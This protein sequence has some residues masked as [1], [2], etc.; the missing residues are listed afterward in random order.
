MFESNSIYINIL[1]LIASPIVGMHPLQR[2]A[3]HDHTSHHE[4]V[5]SSYSDQEN[6]NSS[7]QEDEQKKAKE[8]AERKKLEELR[9][10]IEELAQQEDGEKEKI[11][12]EIH[13]NLA[14]LHNKA[15]KRAIAIFQIPDQSKVYDLT[16]QEKERV[17]ELFKVYSVENH[18]QYK[19]VKFRYKD[20][21]LLPQN[22][23]QAIYLLYSPY[24]KNKLTQFPSILSPLNELQEKALEKQKEKKVATK[25]DANKVTINEIKKRVEN[26]LKQQEG[27]F[28]TTKVKTQ[29]GY[30]AIEE[31]R[32]GDLVACYDFKNKKEIYNS[33]TYADK[34]HLLNHIQIIINDEVLQ[35]AAEHKFYIS[36]TNSWARAKDLI[37]SPGL[38]ALLDPRIQDVKEVAEELD[39]IR[40]SVNNQQNYYITN[41][42][43][44]VHNF[45]LLDVSILWG[46]GEGA[47]LTW[48]VL[49]PT[50]TAAATGLIYWIAGKFCHVDTIPHANIAAQQLRGMHHDVSNPNNDIF[51][52]AENNI[53]NPQNTSKNNPDDPGQSN[54]DPKKDDNK[55]K[56]ITPEDLIKDLPKGET[57]KGKAK[58][59]QKPDK[60]YG[61]AI[62]DFEKL[63]PRDIKEIPN[64]KRGILPDGRDVNVRHY[65]QDGRATL[66]I[67]NPNKS[68]I[69]IRYGT[70]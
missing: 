54:I 55:D 28:G 29:T 40:I 39:V 60:T 18:G 46:I 52:K 67:Q 7:Q 58:I 17:K 62:K 30:C 21:E 15:E 69:K 64:G 53:P 50:L 13:D 23:E 56:K 8:E 1:I 41:N 36:S 49:G 19:V 3:F 12:A 44:L 35:V 4:D 22:R 9:S 33:V 61:D 37:D 11:E 31:L 63:N 26:R 16:D 14:L 10:Y 45:L 6:D 24:V 68:F 32:V 42:N 38:R 34:L 65:S 66:E 47:E 5:Y 43:L 25:I 59:F 27:L 57:T 70:K 20:T 2:Q 51:F 48:A